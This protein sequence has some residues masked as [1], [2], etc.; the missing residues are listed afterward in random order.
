MY[1]AY[2]YK[3][4]SMAFFYPYLE[5]LEEL[6][7]GLEDLSLSLKVL[8]VEF[9]TQALK[10]VVNGSKERL[11]EL[12]GEWN[13]LFSTSLKAPANETAYELDKAGRKASEL[14]DIEGFYKAFGVDVKAPVEPDSLVA[15][16]EFMSYLLVKKTKMEGEGMHEAVQIVDEAYTS[17]FRDHLGRWYRVFTDLLREQS[18]EEYYQRMG[19]LLRSFLDKEREGIQGI[20]DLVEYRK[21]VLEGV[22]WK[23]GF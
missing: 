4:L 23:C 6:G 3:F 8:S 11:L 7:K 2:I 9:D 14:A 22:N 10:E 12:Q 16:L 1:R 20:K 19:A 15:E 5:L 21:E 13:A 17:F 18:K